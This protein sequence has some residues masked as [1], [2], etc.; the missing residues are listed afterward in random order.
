[1]EQVWV[2]LAGSGRLAKMLQLEQLSL[3]IVAGGE[4]ELYRI[5]LLLSWVSG[6]PAQFKDL[7]ESDNVSVLFP[8]CLPLTHAQERWCLLLM[9]F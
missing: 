9:R 2:Q 6:Y 3:L 1:M 4:A 8:S 7:A 5:A